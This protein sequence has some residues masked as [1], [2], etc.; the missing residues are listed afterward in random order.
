LPEVPDVATKEKLVWEKDLLGVYLSEH[1]LQAASAALLR[2]VSAQT[3]ELNDDFVGQKV[4]IGGLLRSVRSLV[5]KKRD[6][7]VSATIEDL[8]GTV[9]VV[10]FPRTFE[11]TKEL[12]VADSIVVVTGKLDIREERFQ[13]IVESA[14]PFDSRSAVN[15]ASDEP[16][17]TTAANSAAGAL[18]LAPVVQIAD[19]QAARRPVDPIVEVKATAIIA[20]GAAGRRR[21]VLRLRRSTEEQA[22]LK[23]LTEVCVILGEH[24]GGGDTVHMVVSGGT[25]PAVEL[26]WPNH[27]VRWDRQLQRKLEGVIGVASV[28]VETVEDA[29]RAIAP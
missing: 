25:R 29:G 23:L 5:T 26:E 2:I 14:D 8:T 21:L 6:I 24:T 10:V 7:M 9:E 16:V 4:T 15:D 18:S 27:K 12:G 19:Y 11:K 17:D 28:K 20:N 22:D 3:A 1:P 13:V